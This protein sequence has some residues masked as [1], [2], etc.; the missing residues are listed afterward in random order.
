VEAPGAR[1]HEGEAS[2]RGVWI[3]RGRS[4]DDSTRDRSERAGS[5]GVMICGQLWGYSR[6]RGE[7]SRLVWGCCREE[8]RGEEGAGG[9]EE[10]VWFETV[11]LGL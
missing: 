10:A 1:S 2:V 6:P 7:A 5:C 3:T 4:E 8:E 11:Y 9:V